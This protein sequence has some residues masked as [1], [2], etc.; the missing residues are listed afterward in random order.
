[1]STVLSKADSALHS[2]R[3]AP[4]QLRVEAAG[5]VFC[6]IAFGAIGWRL[7]LRFQR[8]HAIPVLLLLV[9]TLVSTAL[10]TIARFT[11]TADRRTATVAVTVATSFWPLFLHLGRGFALVPL[12][13]GEVVQCMGIALQLWAKLSLGR[14]YGLLPA[15]RGV[16]TTG[17]Y[18][19]VRHPVYLGYFINHLGF[20][21]YSLSWHNI[22]ILGAI[23]A[24][25]IGRMLFEERT[26]RAD[27][28]YVA[29]MASVRYRFIPRVF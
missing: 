4:A 6:V 27:P 1:M 14:G 16:V 13:A 28:E 26:L 15:N 25:E 21:S 5:R 20:L 19:I 18:R 10:V 29:Y 24:G 2:A 22:A 9:S 7:G 17:P 23:Y 8:T 11:T 3:P 12:H